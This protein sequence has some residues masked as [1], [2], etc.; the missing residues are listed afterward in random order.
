MNA[1]ARID[2][3]AD[4]GESFG[5]RRIGDEE[6]IFEYVTSANVACGFHAGD[7]SVMAATVRAAKER[8]VAVGVHPSYPD[9]SGFGRRTIVMQP[10]E[11]RQVILYQVGA[12][13]AIAKAMDVKLQH[14]KP[15]GALYNDAARDEA[16]ARS[17]AEAVAAYD[18]GLILV[19]LA[20]SKLIAAGKA[21]GL[22]VASEA[23][24]DRVYERDGSLRSRAKPDALLETPEQAAQQALEIATKNSVRAAGGERVNI[25]AQT[26]CIH[27][28]SPNAAA[29][30]GQVRDSLVR[31]G[32]TIA[33]MREVL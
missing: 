32:V 10:D 14:V 15:H 30:A 33:H 11:L 18:E 26:I 1:G 2:L 22:R 20:G 16:L 19:G 9:A 28:D 31:A 25:R 7:P 29:V 6:P 24:C 3:N 21:A 13:A 17:I 12:L 8:N 5:A 27:G 23:F 4:V